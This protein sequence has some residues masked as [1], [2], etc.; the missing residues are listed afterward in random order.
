MRMSTT[1][2]VLSLCF[3]SHA[4]AGGIHARI[5]GPA[6]DGITYTARVVGGNGSEVIEPWAY[7]EGVVDSMRQ[8]VLIRLEPTGT[9][10]EYRFRREWPREGHWMIR[11][12]LGSP[13]A[14]ATVVSLKSDGRVHDSKLAPRSDGHAECQ[15]VLKKW[16][17]PG[18][19][20]C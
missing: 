13:P 18:Q 1:I 16:Q 5:E 9:Q 7:A 4:V 6:E 2:L 17:K 10:G 8:S 14:P 19:P 11:Y 20:D 12:C 15:Q 3:A